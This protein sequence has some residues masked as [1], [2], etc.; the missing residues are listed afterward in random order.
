MTNDS[1]FK[2]NKKVGFSLTGQWERHL[3]D[4]IVPRVPHWIHSYHLTLATLPISILIIAFSYLAQRSIHWLW[5]V[6]ILIILQWLTDSL[7]GSIGRLRKE[8]LIRWGYYMDHFLDYIFLASLLIGYTLLLPLHFVH[9]NL[10]V[11]VILS[12]F[13]INSFLGFSATNEFKVSYLGIGPTEIRIVFIIINTLLILFGKTYLADFM[14]YVLGA[15][16]LGLCIIVYRT[17]KYVWHMDMTN[18]TTPQK[19][20]DDKTTLIP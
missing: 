7:D 8:G 18:K 10:F 2:G 3:I 12:A 5:L 9:L 13:M 1:E 17:Q 4:Q 16:F 11:L 14:P 6:S 15:T 20:N 19:N